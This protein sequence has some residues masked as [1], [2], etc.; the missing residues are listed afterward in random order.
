MKRQCRI[1]GNRGFT[2]IELMISMFILVIALGSAAYALSY[3]QYMSA[4]SRQR[5]LALHAARSTLETIKNTGLTNVASIN[6]AGF[7]PTGLTNGAV[8]ISTNPANLA[9]VTIATVTVTVSW[10]GPRNMARTLRISTM[11]SIY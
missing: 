3:A 11:R 6:T 2:L 9:G 5:L 8:T 1:K 4:D 7:I 10:T